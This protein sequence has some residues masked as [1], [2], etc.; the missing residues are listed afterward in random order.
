MF[1]ES[2]DN[3]L[4]H[5]SV[6]IHSLSPD[7]IIMYANQYELEI[8]GYT[9]DE[10]VGHHTSQFQI[11]KNS[12]EDMMERITRFETLKNYPARVQGKNSIKYILYNSNVYKVDGKIVHTRCFGI[13]VNKDVYEAFKENSPYFEH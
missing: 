3:F 1:S 4:M 8:L 2:S 7:G 12:L 6:G 11:D 10:Y 9:R 13:D 5:S